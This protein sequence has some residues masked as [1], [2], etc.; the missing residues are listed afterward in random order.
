MWNRFLVNSSILKSPDPYLYLPYI[1][2]QIVWEMPKR[3]TI[4]LDLIISW[5]TSRNVV[6]F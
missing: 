4:D 6:C 5:T 3:N 2:N 1:S